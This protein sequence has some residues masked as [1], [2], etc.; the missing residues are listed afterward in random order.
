MDN[1]A[2]T[3][4]TATI[5]G[6]YVA[7]NTLRAEELPTL[8]GS[9]HKALQGLGDANLEASAESAVQ[10]SKAAIR[11]SITPEALIS[12]IDG[13][14]YKML[15][16]HLNTHGMTP[17]EYRARFGLPDD[18]PLTAPSHSVARSNIAKAAGLGSK[19]RKGRKTL[20]ARP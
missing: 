16:R 19:T 9:V 8:I 13:R 2:I 10:P 3:A 11:K 4:L 20:A 12:F 5:V 1:D 17:A 15:K 14:P 6:A 18:Y 7:Q